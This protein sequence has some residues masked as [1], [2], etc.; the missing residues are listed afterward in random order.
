ML[1]FLAAL[2][3]GSSDPAEIEG[4]LQA[5]SGPPGEKYT[6]EQLDQAVQD[7]LDGKDIDYEGAWGPID[8][9]DKGDPGSAIYEVWKSDG[10][11]VT[12]V[13]TFRFEG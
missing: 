9:D 13:K 2:D 10:S 8:F 1:A 3:A 12:T 7:V 11:T 6:F 4:T 5:V